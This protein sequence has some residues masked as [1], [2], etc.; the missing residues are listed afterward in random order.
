MF[1]INTHIKE[2]EEAE[3]TPKTMTTTKKYRKTGIFIEMHGVSNDDDDDCSLNLSF[4]YI[5]SIYTMH[6]QP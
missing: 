2:E 5:H 4:I 1:D 6:P 3:E